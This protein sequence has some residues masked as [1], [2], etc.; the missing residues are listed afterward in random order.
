M[1]YENGVVNKKI[2][3]IRY[4]VFR[5]TNYKWISSLKR[6]VKKNNKKKVRFFPNTLHNYAH[7]FLYFF[8]FHA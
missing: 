8:L 4:I 6:N 7:I 2:I 1:R 3:K 5:L